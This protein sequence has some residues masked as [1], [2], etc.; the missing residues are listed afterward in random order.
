MNLNPKWNWGSG[1]ALLY[2]TFAGSIIG[3]VVYSFRQKIDLV[4]PEYYAEELAYQSQIDK[5]NRARE[6]EK[7]IDW[8]VAAGQI[9]LYFP[10]TMKT[11]NIA[12][13]IT[14]FK[15]SD[16]TADKQFQINSDS[17]G[18]QLI[19]VSSLPAGKYKLK[20][21]WSNL[22][23]TYYQEGVVVLNL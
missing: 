4:T 14:L 19:D 11:E 20:L 7:A 2:I 5:M 6:L 3:M 15:P 1:I 17:A 22:D 13:T 8:K 18:V 16:N 23:Q 9:E 12:G 10:S 21:D